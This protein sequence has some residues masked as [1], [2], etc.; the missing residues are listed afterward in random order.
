MSKFKFGSGS[1]QFIGKSI[2][3]SLPIALDP[4]QHFGA[5]LAAN[6]GVLYYSDGVEWKPPVFTPPISRPYAL[7]PTTTA[8]QRLLRLSPFFS[9][10]DLT[11]VGVVFEASLN[12]DMSAPFVVETVLSTTQDTY[13]LNIGDGLEQGQT[14]YWR[15]KYLGT[16]DQESQFSLPFAQVFPNYV[17]T[18]EVFRNPGSE[19]ASFLVSEYNSP[20]ALGFGAAQWQVY[21]NAEGTGGPIWALSNTSNEILVPEELTEGETY[22]WRMR[23]SSTSGLASDW[24][25]IQSYIQPI[26]EMRLTI[27]TNL[28]TGTT[29]SIPLYTLNTPERPFD[30]TIDWGDGTVENKTVHGIHSH[31]YATNDIYNVTVS[32]SCDFLGNTN[33]AEWLGVRA[34]THVESFGFGLGLKT[35]GGFLRGSRSTLVQLPTSIPPTVFNIGNLFR[36]SQMNLDIGSWDPQ[37]V[38]NTSFMFYSAS[39][40][41]NGGSPSINN[42]RFPNLINASQMFGFA[43]VFNQP[44]GDWGMGSLLT[45]EYMFRST[46]LFNQDIGDWDMSAVTNM[47]GMFNGAVAFNNG[48]V[49]SINNWDTSSLTLMIYMFQGASVFNQ[50][51][52]SWYVGGA[53]SLQEVFEQAT[54]FNQDIGAWDVSGVAN[55]L[56]TFQNASSFNNG[57]SPSINNWN[58]A[59]FTN[60]A[61]MFVGTS[62]FNQPIGD[63]D[64]S[65]ATIMTSIFNSS[66]FDQNIGAWDVGLIAD[67]AFMFSNSQFNNGGS[68]D[69]QNWN[70]SSATSMSSMFR[71]C[72]FNQPIGSWDMSSVVNIGSMFYLNSVFN[73]GGSPDIDNWNLASCI[74]VDNIFRE[75]TSFNQPIG[76]WDV[77][78]NTNFSRLFNSA[79]AFNQDIGAWDVSSG[80]DFSNMFSSAVAFNNGGSPSIG[81]WNVSSATDMNSMM[82]GMPVFDQNIGAWNVSNVTVMASMFSDSAEFNNGGS[83]S[84]GN[85]DTSSVISGSAMFV[86]ARK[87]N[88]PIGTWDTSGFTNLD[89]MFQGAFDFDQDLSGWDISNVTSFLNFNQSVFAATDGFSTSNYDATLIGWAAQAV[90]PNI[91]LIIAGKYS[92]AGQAA[93]DTL[94]SAPNNWTI[95]D[96][97]LVA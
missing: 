3:Y 69:I 17:D 5:L 81:N 76:S 96:R 91:A 87:F 15:G 43:T 44:I 19:L 59:S 13:T 66:A 71:A 48:G 33:A 42:W 89:S 65:S 30:I 51:I 93:R 73:N 72:S 83:P 36:D 12:A 7:N 52:G 60:M 29:I 70:T 95:S 90:R 79:R 32:G 23:Y 61:R 67:M 63:W 80:T 16:E 25:E 77:S 41:D 9:S 37:Y 68:P 92:S 22:Y 50:P 14:F 53:N 78:R 35:L 74:S 57:G 49:P 34:I 47:I 18:P 62:S 94:T 2:I 27:D 84:I 10:F 86:N 46:N 39:Q 64:T 21:D 24:T 40:F 38:T 20:F 56:E 75:A 55:T 97:G 8:E 31:T 11:Q 54:L 88:Q 4:A 58:T 6:D 1:D 28:I 82:R 45:A 26:T 85:W